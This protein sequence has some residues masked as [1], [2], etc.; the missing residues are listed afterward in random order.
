MPCPIPGHRTERKTKRRVVRLLPVYLPP[1]SQ[2]P[3]LHFV[4]LPL[5][6]VPWERIEKTRRPVC[7]CINFLQQHDS[8][9]TLQY[10]PSNNHVLCC[11]V[12]SF[13]IQHT[14]KVRIFL[15]SF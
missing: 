2:S 5:L 4:V 3:C 12:Q 13:I 14:T 7:L 10:L 8:S 9:R 11:E 1:Y 15:D 6:S